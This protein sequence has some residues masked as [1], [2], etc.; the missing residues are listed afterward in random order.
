MPHK[1]DNLPDLAVQLTKYVTQ[2]WV[3]QGRQRV[4]L[5]AIPV[6]MTESKITQQIKNHLAKVKPEQRRLIEPVAKYRLVGKRHHHDVMFRYLRM[7]FYHS[8][9][10]Y[11]S[12]W[13]AAAQAQLSETYSSVLDPRVRVLTKD[14]IYDR[15]MLTII[16]SLRR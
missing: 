11:G 16:G 9:G 5:L 4:L 13:R 6:G 12:I 15:E 1:R 7:V 10:I 14:S 3:G 2:D 8:N